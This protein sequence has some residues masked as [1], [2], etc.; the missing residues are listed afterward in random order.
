M[1][2]TYTSRED[3]RRIAVTSGYILAKENILGRAYNLAA[4]LNDAED[5]GE[6]TE[7]ELRLLTSEA[8]SQLSEDMK[9]KDTIVSYL[10]D[11]LYSSLEIMLDPDCSSYAQEHNAV[12]AVVMLMGYILYSQLGT[13]VLFE[14]RLNRAKAK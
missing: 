6:V 5:A 4:R 8:F 9:H 13:G 2:Y 11:R 3:L 1:A 14:K 10:K 7:S 12:N